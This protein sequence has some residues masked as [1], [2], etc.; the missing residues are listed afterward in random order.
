MYLLFFFFLFF[1]WGCAC[2]EHVANLFVVCLFACL[3]VCLGVFPHVR[4]CGWRMCTC[5]WRMCMR[6]MYVFYVYML[7]VCLYASH[8]SVCVSRMYP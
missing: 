3:F 7:Y 5:G 1:V 6:S 4:T 2:D 8:A